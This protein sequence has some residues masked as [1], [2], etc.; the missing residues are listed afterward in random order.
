MTA[1]QFDRATHTYSYGGQH[2][3][4]VTQVL[5]RAGQIGDWGTVGY[6]QR[7]TTVHGLTARIDRL[8]QPTMD[9]T[10]RYVDVAEELQ[11][12]VAS[13][14]KWLR[15]SGFVVELIETPVCDLQHS[16]AGTPDRVGYLPVLRNTR[17]VVDIKTNASG[18]IA[19]WVRYQ[20]AAYAMMS[21][22][23]PSERLERV[24]I[25]LTPAK[26]SIQ[27]FKIDTLLVDWSQFIVWKEQQ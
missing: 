13:W 19:P 8:Q 5:K 25:A 16:I 22:R 24:A 1:L 11:G 21:R 15:E 10:E 3:E 20:L 14:Q 6:M 9:D 26:Y 4:S 12:Y 17:V 27:H 23:T 18:Q 7:G 2:L